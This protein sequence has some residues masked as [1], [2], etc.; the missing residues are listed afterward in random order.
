MVKFNF[1]H[2]EADLLQ[3]VIGCPGDGHFGLGSRWLLR[4]HVDRA[5]GWVWNVFDGVI[6]L[7]D[8]HRDGRRCEGHSLLFI[9]NLHLRT[10]YIVNTDSRPLRGRLLFTESFIPLNPWVLF[11]TR[12]QR[13]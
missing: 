3:V 7:G 8:F 13:F 2:E 4:P 11:L 5:P 1:R 12:N 6:V 9:V 10:L